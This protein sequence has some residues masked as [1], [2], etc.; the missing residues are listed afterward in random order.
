MPKRR[1]NTRLNRTAERIG[2]SLGHLAARYDSW[3]KQR[4][5]LA[6]EIQ[7]SVVAGQ[8]MLADLDFK[9]GRLALYGKIDAGAAYATFAGLQRLMPDIELV[10]QTDNSLLFKARATMIL[11]RG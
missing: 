9:A 1:R 2:A 3:L 6:S 11:R 8:K 7:K 10:G 4:D 5:E